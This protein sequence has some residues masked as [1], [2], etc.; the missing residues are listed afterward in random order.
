MWFGHENYLCH[1]SEAFI[2]TSR[3]LLVILSELHNDHELT[4]CFSGTVITD[5]SKLP[6]LDG[7]TVYICGEI[8]LSLHIDFSHA[9]RV[10][11]INELSQ[12]H[13][14]L[15]ISWEV[16][17]ISMVPINIHNVGVF[18]RQ[19]FD[20]SIDYFHEIQ[21]DHQ[22][23]FLTES[24][25]PNT[26]HRKGIYLTHVNEDT[27]EDIHF[28]LLRCSSNFSGP[29]ENFSVT[30]H[31]I[32][33][34]LNE[35]VQSDFDNSFPLNHVLAQVYINTP[36]TQ[37]VRQSKAKIKEHS[38][39]TKDMPRNG[40][41]AFCTFY[42]NL[43]R[44]KPMDGDS[45]DYGL[46]GISG[47]TKLRFRLKSTF[48]TTPQNSLLRLTEDFS[49]TLYPHSVF[50]IPLSTNR[51][52]THEIVTSAL[53][54]EHLP[55][56]LGYVVRCSSTEAVFS[57]QDQRTLIKVSADHDRWEPLEPPT[58]MGMSQLRQLY[59]QE[60][61]SHDV[62]CYGDVLFSMNRGDYQ[63]PLLRGGTSIHAST[64]NAGTPHDHDTV[65][66]MRCDGNQEGF[67]CIPLDTTA[68]AANIFGELLSSARLDDVCRGR[69]GT[70]LVKGDSS[71]GTPVVR[72]TTRYSTPAQ[73][74]KPIHSQLADMIQRHA[75]LP[76]DLNNAMIEHYTNQYASMKSHSDHALDL[77]D[78]SHVAV[79]S[80]YKYPDLALIH[81]RVLI[82][83]PKGG[84]DD[85]SFTVP[86]LHNSVVVFSLST[87]QKNV[88]KIVLDKTQNAND[89][90][91]WLGITF[92]T[93]KT[94]IKY[95]QDGSA[96]FE[97]NTP[98]FLVSDK[99]TCNE[100]FF[101]RKSENNEIDFV[102]PPLTYTISPSD[103]LPPVSDDCTDHTETDEKYVSK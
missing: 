54:V 101:M 5:I 44:L 2:G 102:Y 55:T 13:H 85:Q 46:Y 61:Q 96:W 7:M 52:Y 81:P 37:G 79:F 91:E 21:S 39:K 48:C 10:F 73:C 60:N 62:V 66:K 69:R 34:S 12:G 19:H 63:R 58:A 32:L 23:Q 30:D 49:V 82:V 75:S 89:G 31:S 56:R 68:I 94:Y 35:T 97:D 9:N 29:T 42:T 71:R 41:I 36:A 88:H 38:D 53:S 40:V 11:I 18:Y 92:R 80:C 45:L 72:T 20:K 50:V 3:K 103:L 86:L 51:L 16:V 65:R 83:Q 59:A 74:F 87:N 8:R 17:N 98:L 84:T 26:A 43:D 70:V 28:N 33:K 25:K 6:C 100:F 27:K 78:Q 4:S 76:F 95:A 77:Q 90:N 99:R 15:N 64:G 47:L 22:F 57:A 14:N 24:T 93:S 67:Q 1:E